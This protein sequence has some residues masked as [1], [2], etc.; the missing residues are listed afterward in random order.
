MFAGNELVIA[1]HNSGKLREIAELI[2]PLGLNALS[3]GELDVPEPI[4]DGDTFEAN[5][6]IKSEQTAEFTGKASLAD[7]SGLAIP[8]LGGAPG[9]Y[10]ARWAGEAKDFNF[11]MK[12]VHDELKQKGTEPN[13]TAAYFVCVLAFTTPEKPTIF[14]RGEVHGTLTFPP[15]GKNGFGYD[16]IFVPQGHVTSFAEM[17]STEKHA[18]SHRARAFALFV[19]H[20][21]QL[22]L[23]G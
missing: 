17:D 13:G 2:A 22:K 9:I 8:A 1:T 10:S 4:E 21:E 20:L 11:A 7:D 15:R 5:A 12:R 14:F 16:P 3:S 19:E 23:A 6:A 18:M